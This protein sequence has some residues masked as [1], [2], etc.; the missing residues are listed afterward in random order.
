LE[1]AKGAWHREP[2]LCYRHR[3]SSTIRFGAVSQAIHT[4]KVLDKFFA[5]PRV[6]KAI[7]AEESRTRCYST[8]WAAWHLFRTGNADSAVEYLEQSA[9]LRRQEPSRTVFDWIYHFAKWSAADGDDPSAVRTMLPRFQA[10]LQQDD[11]A[12]RP[13]AA[14]CNWWLDV[15]R[16]YTSGDFAEAARQLGQAETVDIDELIARARFFLLF[17]HEPVPCEVVERFWRDLELQGF[18]GDSD[19]H[20]RL[21]LKLAMM[22]RAFA[23]GDFGQAMRALPLATALRHGVKSWPACREFAQ[24]SIRYF[25]GLSVA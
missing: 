17:S 7:R 6:P 5:D 16:R 24:T 21:R 3:R 20:H 13:T 18:V 25:A 11:A 19:S 12:W 1:G 22:G 14:W 2:T 9:A 10:A 8:M 4:L 15:W 23:T